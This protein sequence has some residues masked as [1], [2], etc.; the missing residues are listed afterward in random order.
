[1]K[2]FAPLLAVVV[3]ACLATG[4]ATQKTKNGRNTTLLGGLAR[5]DAGSYQA[6]PA[7][8]IPL[9]GANLLGR[10]NPSGTQVSVL[11]GLFT[12]TDN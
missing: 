11:W 8:T 4:C 5:V 6:A 3:L 12:Y 10:N 7:T 2:R 9:E 1:M